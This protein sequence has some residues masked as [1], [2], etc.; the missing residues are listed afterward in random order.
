[1][2]KLA[3]LVWG[4]PTMGLLLAVGLFLSIRTR[5][6]QV[7]RLGAAVGF[8]GQSGRSSFR[9]VCTALAGTVGTGNIAGV[10]GAIALGGPGTVFWMWIAAFFGMATKYAEV[11]LA[12]RY[13]RKEPDGSWRGGAMYYICDGMGTRWRPLA[14]AFALF[15][16]LASLGMG[17]L[18]QVHTMSAAVRCVL[19]QVYPELA[20]LGTGLAAALLTVLV[21]EG[22]AN[23][24]GGVMEKLLPLAAG[25]Y[26]LGALVFLVKFRAN[27][28]T[29][30][31]DIFR[32][33]FRPEAVLGG[34][35]GIGI[36]EAMR[37][38]VSRGVFSNEAG[39]GSAPMAHAAAEAAAEQQALLGIF[40]VFLD[41]V[42]LCTLTALVI[43]VS[44]ASISWGRSSGA[45]LAASAL[46]AAFG[47][48]GPIGLTACVVLLAQGS[49]L[50]WQYYGTCCAGF[51]WGRAGEQAYRWI[52]PAVTLLGA[53]MELSRVWAVSDLCNGLMCIPNLIALLTL[54]RQIGEK[55][56]GKTDGFLS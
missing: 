54:G 29:A 15:A 19:P 18:A 5:F 26:L 10:A 12:M 42:V 16:V 9:A 25:V 7:R 20:A 21:A 14:V 11:V 8:V 48:A 30:I 43:L 38:G 49:L 40:E 44:G 53:T 2:E 24:L 51:L 56:P 37:W 47:P 6:V 23:R 17:N 33:A 46:Q 39:L 55:T 52:F 45:E 3:A 31:S 13:R 35:A 1:M 28:G 22:G 36:G 27:L 50:A 4:V 34:G 41:T 32:G